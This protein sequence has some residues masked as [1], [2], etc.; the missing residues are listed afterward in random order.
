MRV[1][2]GG[3]EAGKDPVAVFE[4]GCPVTCVAW[5]ADG[6]TLYAGALDNVIHV[7]VLIIRLDIV[8]KSCSGSGFTKARR[9][10][11]AEWPRRYSNWACVIAQWVVSP[12][13]IVLFPNSHS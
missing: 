9:S 10:I 5:S 4:L 8:L 6:A 1:W 7:R 3:D 2:E 13:T 12:F 11:R